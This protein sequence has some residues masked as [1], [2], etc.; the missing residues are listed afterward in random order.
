MSVT[1]FTANSTGALLLEELEK[2]QFFPD[3]VTYVKG[4][5]RTGLA[6]DLS[7]FKRNFKMRF[8]ASNTFEAC[9]N[10][11]IAD[12]S[13]IVC[14]DW[15]KDFFKDTDRPVIY[16]H[17]SKLPMY[18]G[19]SAVTEQFARGV[20]ASGASF[21]LKNERVD[22]GDIVDFKPVRIEFNDYPE[23]FIKKYVAA[24]ADFIVELNR[25]G[26]DSYKPQPQNESEAFYLQRKRGKDAIID[27]SRDA[28]SLYNHIRAYSKPFFGAFYISEGGERIPVW[29]AS[30]EKWQ[31][32]YG[33]PGEVIYQ[34]DDVT[35]IACGSGTIII[36][37]N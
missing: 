4:F 16:A 13:V 15:T 21:Y 37:N 30:T 33:E 7:P 34:D 26:L 27:F 22:A 31:G 1:L 28:F 36:H 10:I 11:E 8:A 32:E 12:S 17:P 23:D 5:Q 2:R 3:V 25:R 14:V 20:T 19:Y 24:C 18:R 9:E 35:E 29:R 6:Q